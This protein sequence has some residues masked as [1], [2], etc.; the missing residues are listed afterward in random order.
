MKS[1]RVYGPRGEH[2][3]WSRVAAGVEL[4]L[5]ECGVQVEFFDVA[6][7]LAEDGEGLSGL[8]DADVGIYIGQPKYMGVLKSRGQHKDRFAMIAANSSWVPPEVMADAAKI[9]TGLLAPSTWGRGVLR[10]HSRGLP[11]V[12]YQHGVGPAFVP[13]ARPRSPRITELDGKKLPFIKVLHL[14]STGLDRKGTYPLIEAWSKLMSEKLVPATSRLDLVLSADHGYAE[15]AIDKTLLRHPDFRDSIAILPRLNLSEE[16]MAKL[17]REY[18]LVVQPSR[19]EGFGLVPLEA[20]ACGVPVAATNNT[21]HID[22]MQ[23]GRAPVVIDSGPESTSDDGPGAMAPTVSADAVADAI[24]TY[25]GAIEFWDQLA[26]DEAGF[27]MWHWS[28]KAVTERFLEE[29]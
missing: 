21:G 9:C 11:V 22:H 3:S 5:R 27:M 29:L 19:A 25:Y 4:G 7:I 12:L 15:R 6:D 10:N 20:R 17:Y 24:A 14:A 8:Y 1:F 28:W 13:G 2:D 18:D 16:S 23:I 26:A